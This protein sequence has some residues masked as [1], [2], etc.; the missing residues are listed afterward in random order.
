MTW[1]ADPDTLDGYTEG[2]ISPVQASSVEAH[3][4]ACGACRT[5]LA[6]RADRTRLDA[7]WSEITAAADTPVPGPVERLL[8]RLGVPDHVGRLLAATP[9]L[10]VSWL[11]AVVVTLAF[12]VSA[13]R[14]GDRG[15]F[16]F[17]VLAPLLPLAGVAASFGSGIDPVYEVAL[18]APLR[19]LDLLLVR[20]TAVLATTTLLAG[21]AA[22]A[23]PHTDWRMAAWLL[24][25]FG[26]TA[27]SLALC[28]WVTPWKAAAALATVWVGA[29]A[30]GLRLAAGTRPGGPLVERFVAFRPSGQ[31]ALAAFTLV[32]AVIVAL[33]RDALEIGRTP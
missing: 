20:A 26:L 11:A 33:R 14:H 3:L 22:V 23:V 30:V 21:A 4:L 8:G 6:T 27:G 9:A 31:L 2:R 29:A 24:P 15:V 16:L 18:A 7:L 28:T 12:A 17:L 13:A 10:R 5:S 1:H 32:A 25:A 19:S